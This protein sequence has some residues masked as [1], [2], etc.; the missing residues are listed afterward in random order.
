MLKNTHYSIPRET[1]EKALKVL[2]ANLFFADEDGEEFN[3]DDA[4]DARSEIEAEILKQ[5][6]N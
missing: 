4:W 6:N 5:D 2:Q 3:N 1:L